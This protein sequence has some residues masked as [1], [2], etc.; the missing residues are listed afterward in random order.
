[1][2]DFATKFE[3][4]NVAG[5]CTSDFTKKGDLANLKSDVDKLD[6]DQLEK[7]SSGLSNFK[8]KIDK[9]DVNNLVPVP[10]DLSSLSDVVK[11]DVVKNT[12]MNMINWLKMLMLLRLFLILVI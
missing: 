2:S 8:S 1:M 4:K 3:S 6:I 9:L 7:V 5:V 12:M 11:N 10:D